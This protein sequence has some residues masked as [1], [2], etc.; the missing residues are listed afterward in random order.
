MKQAN[1]ENLLVPCISF[2][3]THMIKVKNYEFAYITGSSP[4]LHAQQILKL[5]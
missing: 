1:L 3:S 4:L 5:G 2:T